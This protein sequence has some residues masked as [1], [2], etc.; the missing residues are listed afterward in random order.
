M[1]AVTSSFDQ[2]ADS[3]EKLEA[4]AKILNQQIEV[5]DKRV[6][7]L[8]KG[9][10]DAA[11]EYGD[12]ATQTLKWEQALNEAKTAANNMKSQLSKMEDGVEDV[13][14]ELEDAEE[15][16][17]DFGDAFAANLLAG[18]I[19]EGVKSLAGEIG[20]L[21][22]ETKEY[23]KIMASLEVSSEKAG[24]TAE[25]T[26]EIYKT[27]YGVLGDEQTAATTTANLQ[28][29]GLEQEK[30][31]EITNAAIG[32]WASYGD[33]IPIDGLAESVNET[34]KSGQ[35]TGT[36]ADVLNWAAEEG[37]TFGV[38][39][40][41]NTKA[42]EEW[43][44]A[45]KEA[46]TAED[47]FN[48]ALQ[49]AADSTERA[50]IV[51]KLFSKQGLAK[52]GE[53]WQENNKDIV[54]ANKATADFQE[55]TSK[56]AKKFSPVSITMQKG[57]NKILD[58]A[59]NLVDESDI[60][61]FTGL[62]EDGA[63]LIADDV[64]PVIKDLFDFVIDNKDYVVSG[65]AGI[66]SAVASWKIAEGVKKVTDGIKAMTTGVEGATAATKLLNGAWKASPAGVIATTIGLVTTAVGILITET[67]KGTKALD[68]ANEA[69]GETF[70]DIGQAAANFQEG[71]QNA[72]TYLSTFNDTLFVSAKDQQKLK[73]NMEQIQKDITEICRLAS[74][75]RRDYT[76]Q[77]IEKLEKL[78]A[79]LNE[80]NEQQIKIEEARADAIRQQAETAAEA[81][82]G[83]LAGY[84][85]EAQRWIATAQEQSEEQIKIIEEQT[86]TSIAL[87]NQ[88]YGKQAKMSNAAYASEYNALLMQKE[89]NIAAAKDEVIK[90]TEAYQEGYLERAENLQNWLNTASNISEQEQKVLEEHNKK[91]ADIENRSN[92]AR[93]AAQRFWGDEILGNFQYDLTEGH[94]YRAEIEQEEERYAAELASIRNQV[95]ESLSEDAKEQLGTW[96]AMLNQT[97]QYGGDISAKNKEFMERITT[98][99]DLLPEEIKQG[100]EGLEQETLNILERTAEN[101]RQRSSLV[102]DA[103]ITGM[104]S[105]VNSGKSSLN[106]AI[107]NAMS[108]AIAAA[109]F[110]LDIH[111]PSKEFEKIGKLTMEGFGLGF[112]EEMDAAYRDIVRQFENTCAALGEATLS[113]PARA[114][115]SNVYNDN[116]RIEIVVN[117]APGQS[118][119]AIA[120]AV[121]Y[122]IQNAVQRKGAVYK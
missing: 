16:A 99:Y 122:K 48:L 83:S 78:F 6:E 116:A 47:Y 85:E 121:M 101:A 53:A 88:R 100:M 35:V 61:E 31:T 21:T 4:Q 104:A 62:L 111:S 75:E 26:T 113:I 23:R 17:F 76:D 77:E 69:L 39:L 9:L 5:Q 14:E 117:A 2:N 36:L 98:V 42:N 29:I 107:N 30:L 90:V 108:G 74:K 115:G 91:L 92:E 33:S 63:D 87:L 68:D 95:T 8:E 19:I 112:D 119:D 56:M 103:I 102:G 49:D 22:E 81:Y 50:N 27:L 12:T 65:L 118:E 110:A 38:K 105:G 43:N 37:E 7:M 58:S 106:K 3:Q 66:G 34:I 64:L 86:N 73:Q 89:L 79:R 32:A 67:N 25:Q 18:S 11:K 80:L 59:S 10:Q 45:V 55:I 46:A 93:L 97:E 1:K 96:I 71:I 41:A 52:A 94:K 120:D 60:E 82:K 40:K 54:E 72:E 109:E 114:G 13:T 20:N 24:Y 15:A 51:L 44:K 70:E 28:A 57:F 84:Q